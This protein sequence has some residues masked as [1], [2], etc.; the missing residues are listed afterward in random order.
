MLEGKYVDGKVLGYYREMPVAGPIVQISIGANLSLRDLPH[1]V[2]LPMAEARMLAGTMQSR[3]VPKH[4]GY[5][6]AMAPEGKSVVTLWMKAD[7]D[8]WRR[9]AF[10]PSRYDEAQDEVADHVVEELDRRIPG[11][12]AAVE[13]V[14]VATPTTYERITE[15]WQ[16][17]IGGWTIT[18]RKMSMMMGK[19]M[20]KQLPGLERLYMCGQWVEPAG[21]VQL[22]AAS[23]R[24]A[25]KLICAEDGRPF[26]TEEAPALP[27][28]QAPGEEVS[29]L[30]RAAH[31][32]PA[33]RPSERRMQS[34]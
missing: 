23:G 14:D 31:A 2:N 29:E 11:F 28:A 32:D 26:V 1:S 16:G 27:S 4:F 25:V 17:A 5:D 20:R 18:R 15:N 34:G 22:S 8:Y 24:D 12:A 3:I 19:G 13:V 6:P 9:A 30:P 10:S 33:E 7:Y 21:N